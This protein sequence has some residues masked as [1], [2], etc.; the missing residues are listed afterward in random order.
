VDEEWNS[1]YPYAVGPTFYGV[2]TA[3]KV[4]SIS[5]SVTTYDPSSAGLE[6]QQTM[7]F[8]LFPNPSADVIVVQAGSLQAHDVTVE[9]LD[10]NGRKITEQAIFQGSTLCYLDVSTL[11]N[12]QYVVRV[13]DNG[14][15]Y[16]YT[17][18]IA[19]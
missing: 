15:T 11:Y 2:K 9:L 5:E 19:E 13:T 7:Q 17:V 10:A 8:H 4:T 1:A 16:S 14:A 12:G 3:A 6:E 18:V